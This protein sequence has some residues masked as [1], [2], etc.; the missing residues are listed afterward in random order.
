MESAAFRPYSRWRKLLI[1]G[2]I[3][4]HLGCI[5]AW[6]MP[7]PSP[8]KT[9]LLGLKLP[10]PKREKKPDEKEALWRIEPREIV[11]TYLFNTGQYQ[12][13]A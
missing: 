12:G 5:L 2:F 7:K 9:F 10:L 11:S 1:S 6:V 4:F 13:W 8:I 3:L